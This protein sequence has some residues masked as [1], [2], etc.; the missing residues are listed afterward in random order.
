MNAAQSAFQ[1]KGVLAKAFSLC[2][3]K[4]WCFIYRAVL[5]LV[6]AIQNVVVLPSQKMIF[7]SLIYYYF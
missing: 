4:Y 2:R 1:V 3:L 6:K 7:K 5:M